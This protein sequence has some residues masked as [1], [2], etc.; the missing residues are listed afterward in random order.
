MANELV[1]VSETWFTIALED[2]ETLRQLIDAETLL[3][4]AASVGVKSAIPV[5]HVS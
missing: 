1:I 5:V 2:F 4:K 3:H